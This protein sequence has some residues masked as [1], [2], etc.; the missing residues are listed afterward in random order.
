MNEYFGSRRI[1][2]GE[3]HKPTHIP[4]QATSHKSFTYT[5]T[6][7]TLNLLLTVAKVEIQRTLLDISEP[8]EK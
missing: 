4:T 7:L 8:R 6:A 2:R 3:K 1:R 5:Y